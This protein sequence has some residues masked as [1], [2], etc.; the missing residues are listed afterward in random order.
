MLTI[1]S[2]KHTSTAML[3]AK[4]KNAPKS[5]LVSQ[6]FNVKKNQKG[7]TFLSLQNDVFSTSIGDSGKQQ[8]PF[9]SGKMRI[10]CGI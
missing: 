1:S 4:I 3:S 10:L 7:D 2:F 6:R 9:Y 8:E 5:H